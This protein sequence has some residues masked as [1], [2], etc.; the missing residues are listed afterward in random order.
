LNILLFFGQIEIHILSL[1]LNG[2]IF[3]I[4]NP[5]SEIRNPQSPNSLAITKC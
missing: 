4:P 1:V 5:N 2:E 3:L